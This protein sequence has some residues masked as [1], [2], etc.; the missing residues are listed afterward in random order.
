MDI[1][2]A[3]KVNLNRFIGSPAGRGYFVP[4][5]PIRK[6][7][8]GESKDSNRGRKSRIKLQIYKEDYFRYAERE[9]PTACKIIKLTPLVRGKSERII[10]SRQSPD[11]SVRVRDAET[12]TRIN[13]AIYPRIKSRVYIPRIRYTKD[14]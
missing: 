10:A 4:T 13:F 6:K 5:S 1:T 12:I 7:T 3:Q 8:R 11:Y 14:K 2:N 9:S